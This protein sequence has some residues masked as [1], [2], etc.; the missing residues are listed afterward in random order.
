VQQNILY[1]IGEG[2]NVANATSLA[3]ALRWANSAYRQ[4]HVKIR[5]KN[6]QKRSIFRTAAGQQ[7]YQAPSDFLGFITM[8]DE[9]NDNVLGQR[10]PEEFSMQVAVNTITDEIFESEHDVAVSLANTS[11]VQY[12]ETVTDDTDHTTV[13]TRDTDYE[14]DYN[15]GTITVLS[16]GTPIADAT[17]TYIDYVCYSDGKPDIFC[18]EYDATNG[19]YA[20]RLSPTPDGIYIASLVYPALPSALSGAVD[21]I[22]TQLEYC[23]ERGGIYFG[24]LEL[25]NG[26]DP[27]IAEFKSLYQDAIADLVRLDADLV[28]KSQTIPVRMRKMDY[29]DAN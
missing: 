15:A 27:K 13:Y 19:K 16:T 10:T 26:D 24:A 11:I 21:A 18:L 3:Y 22:W 23:L 17:D 2:V 8:K 25:L 4:F 5:T 6:L 29:Q 14:M 28:P 9:S 7:T 12:S 1:G 20:F